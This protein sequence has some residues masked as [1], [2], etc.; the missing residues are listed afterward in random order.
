MFIVCLL[1][2]FS[3]YSQEEDLYEKRFVT[4]Y[5][6]KL[7]GVNEENEGYSGGGSDLENVRP[8]YVYLTNFLRE[9]DIRSVV[10]L[11]CGD[12]TFSRFID[13]TDIDYIGYDVVDSVIQ[14]DQ[15]RYGSSHIQFIH[16]NF[17]NEEV[18]QADLMICK[19]VLQHMPNQD[20]MAFL[21]LLPK[22][23]HC[24]ILNAAPTEEGNQEHLI[25]DVFPFWE[26]R[27]IDLTQAPFN[28]KGAKVLQYSQPSNQSGF[29]LLIHVVQ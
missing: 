10:D 20:V 28:V 22:F 29:D 13:W 16:A 2:V 23:K 25:R 3:L 24:L 4:I 18:P 21:K 8:Y 14:K 9:H 1:A 27:G 12:W 15:A 19:H 26:D 5:R 7:W 11:G 17:L 6:D